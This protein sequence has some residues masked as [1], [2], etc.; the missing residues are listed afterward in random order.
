VAA[1]SSR[2]RGERRSHD[3]TVTFAQQQL[4]TLENVCVTVTVSEIHSQDSRSIPQ[5]RLEAQR[6]KRPGLC[7][8]QADICSNAA[9]NTDWIQWKAREANDQIHRLTSLPRLQLMILLSP[10]HLIV[11]LIKLLRIRAFRI[12]PFPRPPSHI[13]T[14]LG[15]LLS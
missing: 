3:E 12:H 10:F 7:R 6:Q 8:E 4:K 11:V 2:A 15:L 13:F 5:R 1:Q 9:T 14:P